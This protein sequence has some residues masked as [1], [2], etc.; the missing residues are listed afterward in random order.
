MKDPDL[1]QRL[2]EHDFPLDDQGKTLLSHLVDETTLNAWKAD[3]AV[4][5]YRKFLFLAAVSDEMVA[6]SPLL[7]RLWLTHIEHT[8]AYIDVFSPRIIGHVIH[9]AP[10]PDH[11]EAT[12]PYRATLALYEHE[13]GQRPFHKVWPSPNQMILVRIGSVF[14]AVAIGA[15]VLLFFLDDQRSTF[16]FLLGALALLAMVHFFWGYW[17][18]KPNKHGGCSSCGGGDGDGGGCGGD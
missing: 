2:T 1:W 15:F 18:V 17:T 9:H 8:R 6:P 7:H 10:G 16:L 13:F 14:S 12:A 11:A 5:E 4:Q 3:I